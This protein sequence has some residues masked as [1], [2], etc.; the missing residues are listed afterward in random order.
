MEALSE[1]EDGGK[2]EVAGG[3]LSAA[4]VSADVLAGDDSVINRACAAIDCRL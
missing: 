2:N 4:I 3:P 1:R